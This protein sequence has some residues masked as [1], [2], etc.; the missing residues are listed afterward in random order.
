[1][2]DSD[3]KR[4][5]NQVELS[6]ELLF[7]R[8]QEEYE[9]YCKSLKPLVDVVEVYYGAIPDSVL[10]EIRNF[11]GHISVAS[12][13]TNE[14]IELRFENIK[15]AHTHLRRILLDCYKLMCIHQQDYIKGFNKKFKYFNI[16]DV[17]DGQFLINLKKY[18]DEADKAFAEAKRFD[19]PGKNEKKQGGLDEVYEKYA[20][21]YNQYCAAVEYIDCHFD[22]VLRIAHKHVLGKVFSI[23]GW[24]ITVILAILA[25]K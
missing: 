2:S 9:F 24:V 21:A 3:D 19:S 17:D 14:S 16:S 5:N 11:V 22:G 4:T 10:N 12:I 8:V 23:L 18:S 15:A 1:M 7:E 20:N 6:E 13:N 25:L